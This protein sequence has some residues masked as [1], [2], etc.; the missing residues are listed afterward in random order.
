MTVWICRKCGAKF[1][2][3]PG[4]T[5]PVDPYHRYVQSLPNPLYNHEPVVE[6]PC[7][8]EVYQIQKFGSWC[9]TCADC[10]QTRDFKYCFACIAERF[11]N[12]MTEQPD[13]YSR[14]K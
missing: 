14:R 8:G 6:D 9:V 4:A 12:T 13:G 3:E 7:R 11:G 1:E 10:V 2:T 5:H